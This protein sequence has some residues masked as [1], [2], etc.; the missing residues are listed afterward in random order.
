VNLS[1]DDIQTIL[2]VVTLIATTG[3]WLFD[4]YVVRRR[5]LSYRV[6]WNRPVD[7]T[8]TAAHGMNL[9]IMHDGTMVDRPSFVVLRVEN[10]GSFDIAADDVSDPLLFT[11]GG[12]RIVH[13]EIQ[14]TDPPELADAILRPDGSTGPE[15]RPYHPGQVDESADGALR[16]PQ[17]AMARKARFKLLVLLSGTGTRVTARAQVSGGEVVAEG[18]RGARSRWGLALGGTSLLVAGVLVGLIATHQPTTPPP[19]PAAKVACPPAPGI[20]SING[21]TAL[22]P[23]INEIAQLYLKACPEQNIQVSNL[24]RTDVALNQLVEA[25][26][27]DKLNGTTDNQ[28]VKLAMADDYVGKK[29]LSPQLGFWPLGVGLFEVIVNNDTEITQLSTTQLRRLFDGELPKWDAADLKGS[30]QEVVLVS[31]LDG[32]GTRDAFEN[33][34]LERPESATVQSDDCVSPGKLG[35]PQGGV[36]HCEMPST[37]AMLEKVRDTPG[38]VGYASKAEIDAFDPEHQH[39]HSVPIDGVYAKPATVT[40]G[41]YRFWAI[42]KLFRY[43]P[44]RGSTLRDYFVRYLSQQAALA[45][46][47]RRGL[48]SCND[49]AFLNGDVSKICGQGA[50]ASELTPVSS[51]SPLPTPNQP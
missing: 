36:L 31:R 42:E 27:R 23:A 49:P 20:L 6:H 14:E 24:D 12:R 44:E 7:V 41:T 47:H 37:T 3:G 8:P 11:F 51:A 34:V 13:Y 25:G 43:G 29:N 18:R 17:F 1:S 2:A 9:S 38:A 46:L 21:S 19:D 48:I 10:V 40:N 50:S 30:D 16:L 45:V 28:L 22:Y 32:S 26:A 35:A 5:R 39:L 4:R 15:L 33:R